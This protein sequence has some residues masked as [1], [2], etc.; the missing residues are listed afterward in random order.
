MTPHVTAAALRLTPAERAQV[1][2]VTGLFGPT[3]GLDQRAL[4]AQRKLTAIA[5][6][7]G[8]AAGTVERPTQAVTN[9]RATADVAALI[10]P[11]RGPGATRDDPRFH[12]GVVLRSS[13]SANRKEP[14]RA[15]G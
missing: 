4:I 11:I 12:P 10:T 6:V 2:E 7:F 8:T 9:P 1:T 5:A 14:C 13:P 3:A 15:Q